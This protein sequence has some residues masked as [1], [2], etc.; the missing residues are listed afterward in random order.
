MLRSWYV[1]VRE[2]I[3]LFLHLMK[4]YISDEKQ[5]THILTL[6]SLPVHFKFSRVFIF[7]MYWEHREK[8]ESQKVGPRRAIW[9]SVTQ[10]VSS[11]KEGRFSKLLSKRAI[12][13]LFFLSVNFLLR[14]I[15]EN[16]IDWDRRIG[17][18][19]NIRSGHNNQ[20]VSNVNYSSPI[21]F[22]FIQIFIQIFIQ[23]FLTRTYF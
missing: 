10:P 16:D 5:I 23:S 17:T 18:H 9:L 13:A 22:F 7:P 15:F 1:G 6:N 12:L 8:R 4:T 3:S 14:W 19:I 20:G 2:D 21:N 11:T